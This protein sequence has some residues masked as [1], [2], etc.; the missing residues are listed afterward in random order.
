MQPY[1]RYQSLHNLSKEVTNHC[2][3]V[4]EDHKVYEDKLASVNSWLSSLEQNLSSLKVD[5]VENDLET[6]GSRLQII[7]SEREQTVHR[8]TTISTIGEKIILD[9]SAQGREIIRTQIREAWER[10]EKLAK[11]ILEEQKKQDA[12]SMQWSSYQETLQQILAWLDMMERSMS[13]DAASA[14]TTL[15]EVKSKLFKSK[16]RINSKH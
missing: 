15:Q 7:L 16:V 9:T 1:F 12:Q 14:C 2:Q 5:E 11:E 4:V 3:S 10:W 8:L 13:Q 6:K